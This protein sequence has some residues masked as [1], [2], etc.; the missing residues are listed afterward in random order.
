ML[1]KEL[2][3]WNESGIDRFSRTDSFQRQLRMSGACVDDCDVVPA[4]DQ[5]GIQPCCFDCFSK[6][7]AVGFCCRFNLSILFGI[8]FHLAAAFFLLLRRWLF[9]PV[10]RLFIRWRTPSILQLMSHIRALVPQSAQRLQDSLP[11]ILCQQCCRLE[12]DVSRGT[13]DKGHRCR[14][15]QFIRSV[16]VPHN[17]DQ[18]WDC[19]P[20]LDF[21]GFQRRGRLNSQLVFTLH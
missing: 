10:W 5:I 11:I 14:L 7:S 13:S 20:C 18:T 9:I 19:R 17:R 4:L 15:P 21:K 6:T 1:E 8:G 2:G 3:R 16:G 12:I